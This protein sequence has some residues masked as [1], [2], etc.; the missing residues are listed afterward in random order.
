MTDQIQD[1]ESPVPVVL[2]SLGLVQRDI[3]RRQDS[4]VWQGQLLHLINLEAPDTL[5]VDLPV[6]VLDNLEQ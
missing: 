1:W 5:L 4:V 6:Q 2:V 3:Q